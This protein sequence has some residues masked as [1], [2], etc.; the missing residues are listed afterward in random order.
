[1]TGQAGTG[2]T[3][4]A[5][6]F[7]VAAIDLGRR[8]LYVNFQENP[9][10][11]ART[12]KSL[13]SDLGELTTRGLFLQYESPVEL[14]IDGVIVRMFNTIR[15]HNINRVV[16]DALGDLALAAGDRERFHDYLYSMC[17]H[18][19]VNGVT[20]LMTMEASPDHKNVATRDEARFS[21]MSDAIIDLR[22]ETSGR[23]TRTLRVAKARGLAHDLHVHEM[24]IETGGIRVK[25][26]LTS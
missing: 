20:T 1:V 15:E 11:L 24:A 14:R 26:A 8:S 16:I 19:I 12:I 25:E 4:L 2:K 22:L 10:Q 23:P 9:T 7:A 5:L 3:T 13:G 21:S 6:Q 17:Q 18:L